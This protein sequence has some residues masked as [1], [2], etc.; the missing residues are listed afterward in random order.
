MLERGAVV[1]SHERR[2]DQHPAARPH[3]T[4]QL[5]GSA[6][7]IAYVVPGLDAHDAIVA[8]VRSGRNSAE[9]MSAMP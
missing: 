7:G 4:A 9:T 1:L 2:R 3:D 8:A 6:H 5:E